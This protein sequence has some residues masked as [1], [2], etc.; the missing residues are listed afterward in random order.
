MNIALGV[1]LL[2]LG[3]KFLSDTLSEIRTIQEDGRGEQKFNWRELGHVVPVIKTAATGA[4][5]AAGVI[6]LV[7]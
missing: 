6:A 1:G 2:A 5:F 3:L 4:A 7:S